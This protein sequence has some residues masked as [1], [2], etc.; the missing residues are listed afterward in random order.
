MFIF[1]FFAK[2]YESEREDE[3]CFDPICPSLPDT[4]SPPAGSLTLANVLMLKII[5]LNLVCSGGKVWGNF[6]TAG[7]IKHIYWE[8]Y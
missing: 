8:K 6:W 1:V 5:Y 4:A 7:I 3:K 2:I